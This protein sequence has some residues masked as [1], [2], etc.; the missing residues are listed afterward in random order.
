[1]VEIPLL[2]VMIFVGLM[3]LLG[4]ALLGIIIYLMFRRSQNSEKTDQPLSSEIAA[5]SNMT[6]KTADST[7]SMP[8]DNLDIERKEAVHN[9][10]KENATE[11]LPPM[12]PGYV[13]L[14]T[15][16]HR[17]EDGQL[18]IILPGKNHTAKRSELSEADVSRLTQTSQG[19]EKW[20]Q[21]EENLIENQPLVNST[22]SLPLFAEIEQK[23]FRE[24]VEI[25][26]KDN[27][28]SMANQVNEVL[29]GMLASE[30]YQGPDIRLMD[31]LHGD[32]L[33]WVGATKYTAI[34]EI[35]DKAIVLLIR[36]AADYWTNTHYHR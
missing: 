12:I 31:G 15:L 23:S 13:P 14:I 26:E 20:L 7:Q 4:I 9:T 16:V 5:V 2:T 8:E 36:K 32:L 35:P 28:M 25:E 29:Q 30:Q 17:N 19:L 21:K 1:M 27:I 3:I 33:I 10:T 11:E 22:V 6:Q 34:D 24:K 18:G